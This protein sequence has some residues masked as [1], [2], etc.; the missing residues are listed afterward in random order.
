MLKNKRYFAK[1]RIE[2]LDAE[3]GENILHDGAVFALYRAERNE[4]VHGDG[5][6]KRY[7][8]DTIISGSQPFL[9]AMGAK[10]ITS[11]ARFVQGMPM[12]IGVQYTGMVPKG[13][14]ICKEEQAVILDLKNQNVLQTT[15]YL[16]T[17]EPIESGV[18]VLAEL[19][20]PS[21]YV[22]SKPI[23]VEV[24][25]DQVQYYPNGGEE[26]AAAVSFVNRMD[27]DGALTEK[28]TETVRIFVNDIATSLEVSK[29]K[30]SDSYRGMK[31]S[32]RVEGSIAELDQLYGLENLEL[33]YRNGKYLG[34]A[35]KKG[36]LEYLENRKEQGERIQLVYEAGIF[37]GY[38]YVTR[39]LETEDDENRYVAGAQL[40]LYNAV[41]IRRSGDTEDFAFSGVQIQRDKYGAVKR[42]TVKEGEEIPV[43]FY[44]LSN[45]EVLQKSPEGELYGFDRNK[46]SVWK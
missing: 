5:S 1:L 10:N 44:D 29:I 23:P 21:G 37:Q 6:V 2:K 7:D 13:T 35:W 31:I 18:Y 25:S 12:G 14:P 36:T 33:A 34:F 16:E 32:G 20:A 3:T 42:I 39:R 41:S 19:K 27:K 43:L 30:T 38:G 45:L 8:T 26:K 46:A 15:G 11:F 9:V 28:E 40:A 4:G 17:P 24:Y 22:R